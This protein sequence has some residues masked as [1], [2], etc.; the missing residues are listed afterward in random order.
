[1]SASPTLDD[2]DRE[3]VAADLLIC[4]LER[5][6]AIAGVM[7]G[8]TAEVS[9]TTSD[10]LLESAYFTRGGVLLT[11]RRL[12]LHSEAS[13]RFERGTDPEGLEPAADRCAALM[14]AWAGGEVARGYAGA[15][16][17]P[18]AALGLRP[19]VARRR[20]ARLPGGGRGCRRACS[21]R[22]AWRTG[23]RPR[24]SRSRC[25]GT[26]PTSTTRST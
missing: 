2:V 19:A 11:A 1:M 7:G 15:G 24:R 5:P 8:Q 4:D 12:D 14:T 16:E 18:A 3:L 26:G 25:P 22:W 10:V 6:V 9:A 23:R 20:A 13:H 17:A 21:T